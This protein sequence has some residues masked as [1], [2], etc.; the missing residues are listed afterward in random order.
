MV[1]GFVIVNERMI[2]INEKYLGLEAVHSNYSENQIV[3]IHILAYLRE[4][5]QFMTANEFLLCG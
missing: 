4:T 2:K 3:L 1:H 5:R